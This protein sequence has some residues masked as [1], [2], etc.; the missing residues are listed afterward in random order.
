M[1]EWRSG[2]VLIW[3]SLPWLA[4]RR[5]KKLKARG[6]SVVKFVSHPMIRVR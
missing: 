5:Q 3:L 2:A 4:D 1:D 6:G